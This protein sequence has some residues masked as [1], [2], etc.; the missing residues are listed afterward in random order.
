MSKLTKYA[1]SFFAD[2]AVPTCITTWVPFV[3]DNIAFK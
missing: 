2:N 3:G 1:T